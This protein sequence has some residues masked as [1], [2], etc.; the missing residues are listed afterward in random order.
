M[1]RHAGP[2]PA[3]TRSHTRESGQAKLGHSCAKSI[4]QALQLPGNNSALK[5]HVHRA[6]CCVAWWQDLS[7]GRIVQK[8]VLESP[9][10]GGLFESRHFARMKRTKCVRLPI[11]M[12]CHCHR[13]KPRGVRLCDIHELR[14]LD[15][16]AAL[17]DVAASQTILHATGARHSKR[18]RRWQGSTAAVEGGRE[19][20][21]SVK[22]M[23]AARACRK[24]TSRAVTAQH[25]VRFVVQYGG[26]CQ[27]HRLQMVVRP[28]LRERQV[29]ETALLGLI[30]SQNVAPP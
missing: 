21:C 28:K 11:V 9:H 1:R 5:V 23:S 3:V 19:S 2:S 10:A 14:I 30:S 25:F 4:A 15:P 6:G 18:H 20:P 8:S 22:V 7:G 13:A 27:P 26:D 29:K 16:V 24:R 12:I 17:E